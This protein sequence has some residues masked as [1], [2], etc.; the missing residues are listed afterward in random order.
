[1]NCM[2]KL[3]VHICYLLASLNNTK[4]NSFKFDVVFYLDSVSTSNE[5][6]DMMAS[7]GVTT[8]SRAVDIRKKALDAHE[9]YVENA[10]SKF[11]AHMATIIANPCLMLAIPRNGAFNPKFI[12]DEL[13]I[14]HLDE[15][16]IINLGIPYHECVRGCIG[17]CSN[18]ELMERLTL[19]SYNDR[20]VEKEGGRHI[21]NVILFDFVEGNLKS[22]E[23]Y[24]KALRIVHN[25]E[26]MQEYLSNHVLPVVADWPGQFFIC[27]AIIHQLLLNNQII[28]PFVTSFIPIMGPL[29]VSLNSRELVFLKNSFLF[30]DIYKGIFGKKKK[31]GNKP[32]P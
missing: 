20:L 17:K 11:S 9:E 28:P 7:L 5:M 30:N 2:K 6:L 23:D 12:D 16:F 22:V 21:Q 14:K 4:I 10:L 15:W 3:I 32:R 26:L 13:I 1:M 27:K 18:N 29:H 19:H 25:Q 24:T 8:T 31:L